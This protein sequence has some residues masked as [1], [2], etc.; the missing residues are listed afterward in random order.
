FTLHLFKN[1]AARLLVRIVTVLIVVAI[2]VSRVYVGV[3]YPTDVLAGWTAGVPWL[4]ACLGLHEVLARRWPAAGEPV[5]TQQ[6]DKDGDPQSGKS[7]V[8]TLLKG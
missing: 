8:K 7:A 5:L 6:A 1:H 2:G 4:I 3:H